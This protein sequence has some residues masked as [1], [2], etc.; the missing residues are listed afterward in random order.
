MDYLLSV[1]GRNGD[2]YSNALGGVKYLAVPA[3]A[4][5][6]HRDHEIRSAAWMAAVQESAG[7]IRNDAGE[8]VEKGH[9][10]VFVHGFNTD[11]FDMLERHRKIRAG[12]EAHGFQGTLISY[13]WPSDGSVLGYCS[14]RRDARLAADKLFTHGI[15][16]LSRLQRPDCAYNIHALA[17]SMGCFL[18]REAF[19][20]AD[21][22]HATA[23]N[24]WIV[25]QVAMVAADI[26]QKSMKTG[27]PSTSSLFRRS[28]RITSYFSPFDDV[29]SISEVKRVGLSRRLGRVGL[30]EDTPD[31][32]VNLYCGEYYKVNRDDFGED[33][34]IAHRW[35]FDSPRF[36]EDL[37]HTLLG[38]LDRHVIPTRAPTTSGGLALW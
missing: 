32:A 20:Y 31:K 19:D 33:P 18:L 2:A 28:V 9:I 15:R 21:D 25:S 26:S 3:G 14:D 30:P 35:H 36:Y 10:V 4:D 22:D 29:L 1:R 5:K 17:H 27:S 24:A 11:Q 23:Q 37:Y 34:G 38:K 6:L 12:L 7:A 8:L 16:P 13:D